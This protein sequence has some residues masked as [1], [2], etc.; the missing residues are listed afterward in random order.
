MKRTLIYGAAIALTL[1]GIWSKTQ[2]VYAQGGIVALATA[3]YQVTFSGELRTV[4]FAAQR[5]NSNN[6]RGEGQLFNHVSGTKIHFDINCLSVTGNQATISGVISHSD[7]QAFPDGTPIWLTVVDN[8]SG[9]NSPPDLVSPLFAVFG[10]PVPCTTAVAAAT[11]P[12]EGGN[13]AVH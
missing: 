7:T 13:I 3:G 10:P 4:E 9:K 11:I 2:R 12:I 8:G 5:D 1:L 6:S